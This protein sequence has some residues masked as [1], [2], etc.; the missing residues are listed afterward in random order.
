MPSFRYFVQGLERGCIPAALIEAEEVYP[1]IERL[2]ELFLGE[3]AR[4]RLS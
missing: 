4:D 1:Q 2:C 3:F